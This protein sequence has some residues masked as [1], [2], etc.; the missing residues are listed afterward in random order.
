MATTQTKKN[1][2]NKNRVAQKKVSGKVG[3]G[4]LNQYVVGTKHL[5]GRCAALIVSSHGKPPTL[6]RR[7]ATWRALLLFGGH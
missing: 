2:K 5:D 3:E 4:S 7:R 6:E 1:R